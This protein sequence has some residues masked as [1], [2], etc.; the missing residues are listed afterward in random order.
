MKQ[1]TQKLCLLALLCTTLNAY[2][3]VPKLSSFPSAAPTI[4]LDFDGHTVQYAGWQSG[5]AFVCAPAVLST[6]QITEIFNRVSEDYRPFAVNITTD[7][8]KFI[9]APLTQRMRIIVTPTSAWYNAP[10]VAYTNSF[11]WGDDAPCF[12]F[13]DK[14]SNNPK[15]IAEGC[16]HESGHTVGLSHQSVYNASCVI[17]QLYNSGSGAGET[18]WAPI[19]GSSYINNMTGW[20][21]GPTPYDCVITQDNISIITTNNGFGYRADD[22]S[23]TMNNSTTSINPDAINTSGIITT[24]SD[25]DAFKITITQN[26]NLHLEVAPFKIGANNDGAN[27]DILLS[28]YNSSNVL[29]RSYNPMTTMNVIVDTTLA[30]GT[31]YIVVDGTGNNNTSQYGSLGSYTITG[32]RGVLAIHN[33]TLQGKNNNNLHQLNWS[34]ISDEPIITQVLE[35][36]SNAIDFLAIMTDASGAKNYDYTPSKSGTLFYRLKVTSSIGESHYSNIV[37]L[38]SNNNEKLFTVSTLVQQDIKVTATENYSYNLY[39][40]NARLIITGTARKGISNINIV[41]LPSGMYIL[42]MMNENYK[43]TERIIKQ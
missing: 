29:I 14:L 10:G 18:S 12:V 2:C 36:S 32:S 37:A 25:K 41:N 5:N 24:T 33:V 27:L 11:T 31:Y 38:K 9:A 21:I 34:I 13:P 19:M 16:S 35:A 42:Q 23:E 43:Q 15:K 7:S 30:I 6:T 3:Q 40:A 20:N 39:D 4:F 17:T 1:I 26:S 8:T 22:Y 28:L